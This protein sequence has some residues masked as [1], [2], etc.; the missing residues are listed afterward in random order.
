MDI[1][2]I[3]ASVSK[4]AELTE[5]LTLSLRRPSNRTLRLIDR[6]LSYLLPFESPKAGVA[7]QAERIDLLTLLRTHRDIL[8]PYLNADRIQTNLLK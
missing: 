1:N 4:V 7:S 2:H 5:Q 6:A 3:E 8:S